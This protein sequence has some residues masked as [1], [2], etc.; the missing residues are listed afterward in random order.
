MDAF[1]FTR[2]GGAAEARLPGRAGQGRGQPAPM[3]TCT[4]PGL[5]AFTGD[6]ARQPHSAPHTMRH[7]CA[8]A[9]QA[10]PG[11]PP[12]FIV[13]HISVMTRLK[14]L[15]MGNV[16]RISIFPS[17]YNGGIKL[18]RFESLNKSSPGCF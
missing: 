16:L 2:A 12:A 7:G 17:P 6:W 4:A 5:R 14:G 10:S 8:P 3:G 15:L 11:P 1:L 13:F 9:A 18:L